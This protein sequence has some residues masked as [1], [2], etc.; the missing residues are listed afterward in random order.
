MLDP[1][2]VAGAGQVGA[3]EPLGD[4]A[5]ETLLPGRGQYPIRVGNEVPR[6]PP[7]DV[8][9]E[10]EVEQ[11]LAPPLVGKLAR[12]AAIEMEQILSRDSSYQIG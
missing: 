4:D 3:A 10:P 9:L 6:R 2:A 11:Q 1:S 5:L 12:R 8:A 7:T